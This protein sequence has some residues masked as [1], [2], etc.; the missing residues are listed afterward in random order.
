[1][2]RLKKYMTKAGYYLKRYNKHMIFRSHLLQKSITVSS[3]PKNE[4][5]ELMLVKQLV[6]RYKRE[7]ERQVALVRAYDP[8]KNSLI[9]VTLESN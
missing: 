6:R 1:M 8:L 7:Y 9:V 5:V 3:T 2:K 4:F